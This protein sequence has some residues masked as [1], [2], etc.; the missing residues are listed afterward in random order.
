MCGCYA[1][2]VGGG[3][4]ALLCYLHAYYAYTFVVRDVVL[5]F[6]FAELD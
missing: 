5:A 2:F 3:F 1:Q 6:G 4:I